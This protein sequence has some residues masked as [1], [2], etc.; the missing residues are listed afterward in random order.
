M[1]KKTIEKDLENVIDSLGLDELTEE[2]KQELLD[3]AIQEFENLKGVDFHD[4]HEDDSINLNN[5]F[6]TTR[7]ILIKNINRLEKLTQIC[8]NNVALDNSNIAMLQTSL[9]VVS[10]QQKAIKLMAELQN[11]LF[12]NKHQLNKLNGSGKDQPSNQLPEGWTT[13]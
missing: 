10:E 7:D 6:K 5:D 13:K 8:I 3:D 12:Q 9:G 1:S 11:K 2:E 4:I